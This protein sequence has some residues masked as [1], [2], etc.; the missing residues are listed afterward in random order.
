[1]TKTKMFA[2]IAG[3]AALALALAGC[4]GSASGDD[5]SGQATSLS[6]SA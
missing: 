6:R 5:A 2:A 4:S 3:A 1:M